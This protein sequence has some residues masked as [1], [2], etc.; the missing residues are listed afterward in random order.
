[1]EMGPPATLSAMLEHWFGHRSAFTTLILRI[2]PGRIEKLLWSYS[3]TNVTGFRTHVIG[4][5][6][7]SSRTHPVRCMHCLF[8]HNKSP[9]FERLNHRFTADSISFLAVASCSIGM[10]VDS[11]STWSASN[12][13]FSRANQ[14]FLMGFC[15]YPFLGIAFT[16][17]KQI[18]GDEIFSRIGWCETLGHR[19]QPL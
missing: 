18:S 3:E 6:N 14:G 16:S 17:P 9:Y 1:M 8:G 10:F 13:T 4:L 11:I 7:S 15:K 5:R 12:P 19:N 2:W